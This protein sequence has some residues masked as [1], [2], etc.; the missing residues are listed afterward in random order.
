MRRRNSLRSTAT[1]RERVMKT[2]L[3][4]IQILTLAVAW[5][6]TAGLAVDITTS[7]LLG[8]MEMVPYS[9]TLEATN[10][11]GFTWSLLSPVVAW[12]ENDEGQARVPKGLTN[13]TA[14]AA[15]GSHSLALRGDGSVIAWGSNGSGQSSVP[16]GLRNVIAI[17]AGDLHSLALRA[18]GRVVAWGYNEYGQV[19]VPKGLTNVVAIAAGGDHSLALRGD[20]TVVAWG[21]N[22]SGQ[23]SVPEGLTDVTAIAAGLE[24]SLALRDDGCVVAWGWNQSGQ[25]SVPEG[26][27][28]VIAIA[29]DDHQ[30]MAMRS[31]ERVVAW[32]GNNTGQT[33]VPDGLT[34]VVAIAAGGY[35]SLALKRS[36]TPLPSGL[37][38]SRAGELSGMPVLAGTYRPTFVVQNSSGSQATKEV[39]IVIAPNPNTRPV[40][41][42]TAP[43]QGSVTMTENSSRG[44][45][46]EAHDTEGQPLT[47][48][49]TLNGEPVGDGTASY[50]HTTGRGDL[51]LYALRCYVSDDL[52]SNH[53]YASWRIDVR[54]VPPIEI[55]TSQLSAGIEMVPYSATLEATNG[56][57]FTWSLPPPVVVWG[58]NEVGQARV[59]KRLS[60]VTAI[61]AGGD[62]SL[63]LRSDG[64]VVAWG[65][66]EYGQVRVPKGLTNVVAIA[67]GWEHSLALR[68]DGTVVAWGADGDGQSSVPE[69]LS[70]VI[71]IAAGGS[72]S[73][74][75]RGDG[76]V[77]AW[78]DNESGQSSV[79]YGLSDVTAIAAGN[80]HS[81]ALR[82]DGSVVA[83]GDN[84]VGQ[85]RV[86][87]RLSD[88]TAIA[89]GNWHCLALKG[90]GTVV[91]W[92]ANGCGQASVPEGLSG[93]TAIAAGGHHSLALKGDG[94]VVAWGDNEYGQ[95]SVPEGLSN[96]TAIAAG[97]SHSLALYTQ[98]PPGLTLSSAGELSGTP[99]LAG[100]HRPT[101]IVQNSSGSQA[102]KEV[103]FVIAPN[104]NTPPVIDTTAPSQGV[105]TMTENSS[106]GFSVVAHDS[107]GQPLTYAWTL[108]GEPVGNGTASYTL[109]TDGG[110]AGGYALRCYVSDDLWDRVVHAQWKIH[111][112]AGTK[113]ISWDEA[114]AKAKADA[115]KGKTLVFKGLYLGMPL[116]D[117]CGTLNHR[118]NDLGVVSVTT[119]NG[120]KR[121]GLLWTMR[122]IIDK[123]VEILADT[124]G[125]VSSILLSKQVLDILFDSENMPPKEFL[126]T[127]IKAYDIPKLESEMK[128]RKVQVQLFGMEAVETVGIQQVYTYRS[129]KGFELIFFG[130]LWAGSEGDASWAA[131]YHEAGSML[132]RK[133]PTAKA[134]ESKFD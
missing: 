48:A 89:A 94:S 74:A 110:D 128:E 60:D 15:G 98:L 64:R 123:D 7:E 58:E 119:E 81:L 16:A 90:D 133:I 122:G 99:I 4:W 19:R 42:S 40:V 108:N 29:A 57:G 113:A 38:L 32:G 88:V 78:G 127:F 91:A 109:T 46:V 53:V 111:V 2:G 84:E 55:L 72:H 56:V 69:G 8:G 106:R 115:Q 67:A 100:T 17:A 36:V 87:K 116:D 20:G 101:F 30:S 52:W 23:A 6:P 92:G 93:V 76:T 85:A 75:L 73:L 125:N 104:P 22:G 70:G 130:E 11:T 59:P 1:K 14:I 118:L 41:D 124:S 117:A 79:P 97:F 65:W 129:P 105:V 12:G 121:I 43:P 49:W 126:Q 66:N 35:H 82:G 54:V 96:V 26:L 112:R 131:D 77:A 18:D 5:M 13:V 103:E 134:R 27:T 68:G 37:T 51:G 63:A 120:Q 114:T 95:A 34:N 25:A 50:T 80:L 61:A 132:L 47:Y 31:E 28:N 24:H 107:E 86:P 33:R 83:W 39:E 62:H 71:A 9:A 45:S 21:S 44:F 102:T 3:R 10:G